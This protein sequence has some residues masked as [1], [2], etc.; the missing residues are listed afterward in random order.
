M[1]D[2]HNPSASFATVW[3]IISKGI[4]P[5]SEEGWVHVDFLATI[6]G[7]AYIFGSIFAVRNTRRYFKIGF[8]LYKSYIYI[9]SNNVLVT[10]KK[11]N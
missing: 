11:K 6:S 3:H 1:I 5:F 2:I 7:V 10:E 4:W 8:S 9:F